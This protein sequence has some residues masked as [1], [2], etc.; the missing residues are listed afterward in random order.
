MG[1]HE[2]SDQALADF[3]YRCCLVSLHALWHGQLI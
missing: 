3:A 1:K 2:V